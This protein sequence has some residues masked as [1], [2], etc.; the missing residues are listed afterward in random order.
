MQ[1]R[2]TDD[3]PR[4]GC[5]RCAS[6]IRW[7][8]GSVPQWNTDRGPS[9]AQHPPSMSRVCVVTRMW[10]PPEATHDQIGVIET[11]RE[12]NATKNYMYT[13]SWFSSSRP[14][15]PLTALSLGLAMWQQHVGSYEENQ[16][17]ASTI[18]QLLNSVAIV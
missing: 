9:W 13:T 7:H 14:M 15:L 12:T 2:A 3:L 8:A 6:D 4:I 18:S 1:H 17:H 10:D 5:A 11:S 16:A